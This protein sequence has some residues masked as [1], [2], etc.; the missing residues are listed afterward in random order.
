MEQLREAAVRELLQKAEESAEQGR[1]EEARTGLVRALAIGP[2][3]AWI[4]A[5]AAEVECAAG[6]K[7]RA[8]DD[9]RESLAL[10]GLDVASEERAGDLALELGDDAMAVSVFDGLA[11][12]DPRFQGRAAEARLAFRI[13]NWPE[14]ERQA[15]RA[16]RL[17]RAGAAVLTW[18]MFPEVREARVQAGVVASDALARRDSRAVMRAASLGL[19]DVDPGTHRARPDAPLLRVAAAR[20]LLR[21]ASALPGAESGLDCLQGPGDPP[22]SGTDAIRVAVRCRL[23]SESVGLAVGGAEFTR[24]LDHLR[25]LVPAGEATY[26]D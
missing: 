1:R 10:G 26:R 2:R 15:A 3:S 7:E 9:Y 22:K 13:A 17:T 8:L 5:R 18:W 11:A 21:L 16:K 20:F 25:S 12:R 19:L 23:L 4:L 24:G 6:E 14:A